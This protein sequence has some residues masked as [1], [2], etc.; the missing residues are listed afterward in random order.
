[1]TYSTYASDEIEESIA[2]IVDGHFDCAWTS[3]RRWILK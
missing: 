2:E 3:V 1:M